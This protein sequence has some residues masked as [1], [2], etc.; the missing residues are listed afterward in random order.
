MLYSPEINKALKLVFE[1]HAG[2]F[3][4]SGLPY[5]LHPIVVASQMTDITSTA[6]ALLHDVI[7]DTKYTADDLLALG[8]SKEVVDAVVLLTHS[9]DEPY[10]DYINRIKQNPVARAVKLADLKHNSDTSR[11]DGEVPPSVLNKIKNCYE[12]ARKLLEEYSA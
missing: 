2:Q 7:E 1:A 11:F 4:K 8:F 6:V 9:S 12:P 10:M 5:V 3:D